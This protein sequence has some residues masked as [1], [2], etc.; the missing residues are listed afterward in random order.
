MSGADVD[1]VLAQCTVD[2]ETGC[3]E[4]ARYRD[5]NG[6]GRAYD[7]QVMQWAHRYAW[8][9]LR[10]P[11][12]KGLQIDH[13]C[14]NPPCVNPDHLEPV[15]QAENIRRVFERNGT[16][17]R[18]LMAARM[19]SAGATFGEISEALG[20]AG[21]GSAKSAVESAIAKGLIDRDEVPPAPIL[22]D[23]EIEDIRTLYAFGIPQTH[24]AAWYGRDGSHISRICSG[25]RR[26]GAA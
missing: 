18:Q 20:L 6:Y 24:I 26:R 14:N 23:A 5:P 16:N 22:S 1:H 10:G 25:R 4:W 12:P 21:K 9:A 17:D 8:E 2:T 13:L 7:G 11:I 19:R 15:T 3:W